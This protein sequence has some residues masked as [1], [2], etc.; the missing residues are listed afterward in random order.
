MQMFLASDVIYTTRVIPLIKNALDDADVGGQRAPAARS[1]CPGIEWLEPDDGRRR[2]RPAALRRRRAAAAGASRR[3]ACTAP[4]ST[5]VQ[6]G[7]Q[8]LAARRAEPDRLRARHRV[9]RQLHQPGRER[10][11]RR[12]GH[13]ADRGRAEADHASRKTVPSVAAGAS[14]RRRRSALDTPPPLDTAGDDHASRS[15][16]V[17]GRAEDGQQQGRVPGAVLAAASPLVALV[18][19]AAWTT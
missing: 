18:S 6:V 19:S 14:R 5:R 8:T 3:P 11:V 9:H 17:P 13:A 15:S 10:R 2:A 4:G 7:D 16:A 1:S 12:Q